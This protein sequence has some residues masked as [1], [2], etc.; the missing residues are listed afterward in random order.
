M[1]QPNLSCE[2]SQID[3]YAKLLSLCDVCMRAVYS[4][5]TLPLLAFFT[6]PFTTSR[7]SWPFTMAYSQINRVVP[8]VIKRAEKANNL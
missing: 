5:L 1:R 6:F 7:N 4:P 3:F 2:M 8:S